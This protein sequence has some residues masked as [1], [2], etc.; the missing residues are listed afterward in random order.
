M[1]TE[2]TFQLVADIGGTNIRFACVRQE[3]DELLHISNMHCEDFAH[4]DDA[5]AACVI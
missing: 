4:L 1:M 3:E 5:I 2:D